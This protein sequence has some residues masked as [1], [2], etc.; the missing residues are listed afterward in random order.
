MVTVTPSVRLYTQS[1]ASFY[2]DPVYDPDVG[3][4]YPPGYFTN[5]PQYISPDQRLSAFGAVTVGLKLGVQITP[6]WTTDLKAEH[7]EQRGSWRVGGTGSPGLDPFR[8]TFVQVG[9]AKRF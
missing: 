1:A 8:A 2:F 7:Y 6:D 4:P 3:A 5:P 9:V